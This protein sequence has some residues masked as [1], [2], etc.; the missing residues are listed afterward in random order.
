MEDMPNGFNEQKGV[1]EE[2]A[3]PDNAMETKEVY[4]KGKKVSDFF[5]GFFVVVAILTLSIIIITKINSLQLSI[6]ALVI[7]FFMLICAS[8]A[9][10]I[11]MRR[12]KRSFIGLGLLVTSALPLALLLIATGGCGL[13]LR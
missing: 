7:D 4:T 8:V 13:F 11:I 1:G 10:I 5:I 3:G 2:P 12:S 9:G 6:L